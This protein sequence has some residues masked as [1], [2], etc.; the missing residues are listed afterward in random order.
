MF[1]GQGWNCVSLSK[2]L[3]Q[4]TTVGPTGKT[5]VIA[6]SRVV[7]EYR[8]DLKPVP[9][10]RPNLEGSHVLGRVTKQECAM[11]TLVQVNSY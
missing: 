1:F 3:L 5:G 7:V 2:S 10:P 4:L 8:I 11:K 9:I 6:Q